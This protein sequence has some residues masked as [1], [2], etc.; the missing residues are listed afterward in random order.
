VDEKKIIAVVGATGAQGGGVCRAVLKDVGG[1]YKVRALTRNA[2]SDKAK[3]LEELGAED[4]GNMF[5]FNRDF[6]SVCCGARSLEFT[7]ELNPALQTFDEWLA[8]NGRRIPIETVSR[9]AAGG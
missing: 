6:E 4:L 2:G 9:R 8:E 7:R 1:G 5:Q 3:E